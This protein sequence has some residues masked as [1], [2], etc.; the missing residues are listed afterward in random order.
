[1]KILS[2]CIAAFL[3]VLPAF[4][5]SQVTDR[6]K[7]NQEGFYPGAP[8][9]AVVTGDTGT[10]K[11]YVTSTNLRDTIFTGTLSNEKQSA[12]SS[13]TTRIADFSPLLKKGSFV[14]CVPEV[15]NS[16][17][18]EINKMSIKMLQKRH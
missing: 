4:S 12:Y 8:K 16:Y 14:V 18:F 2:K 11:F 9:I 6:I 13:T 7:L 5:F 1:M 15:G 3:V 10:G 17:V